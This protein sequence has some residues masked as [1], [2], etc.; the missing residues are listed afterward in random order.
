MAYVFLRSALNQVSFNGKDK[1]VVVGGEA[2]LRKIR[3]H[4]YGHDSDFAVLGTI[5]VL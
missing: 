2:D 3:G 4:V 1:I 5:S